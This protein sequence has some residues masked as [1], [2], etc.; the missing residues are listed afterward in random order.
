[1]WPM[2]LLLEFLG[3]RQ[4]MWPMGLLLEFLDVAHGPLVLCCGAVCKC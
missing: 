2:G 3:V 4:V 1:M